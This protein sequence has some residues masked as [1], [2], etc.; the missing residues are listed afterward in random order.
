MRERTHRALSLLS[1]SLLSA[2]V[3]LV[4]TLS[5][6]LPLYLCLCLSLSL[7]AK[8]VS[9][10]HHGSACVKSCLFD[11]A[12][13]CCP[14]LSLVEGV[15]PKGILICT[16][17]SPVCACVRVDVYSPHPQS[18]SSQSFSFGVCN[19]TSLSLL[20]CLGVCCLIESIID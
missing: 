1:L 6:S 13:L 9:R 11:S 20:F 12:N 10:A 19:L 18:L 5:P 14:S 2:F 4:S 17:I 7:S 3:Q 16:I 8:L 15:F